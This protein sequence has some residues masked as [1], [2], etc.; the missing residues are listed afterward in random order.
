MNES[1]KSKVTRRGFLKGAAAGA[2]ALPYAITSDALGASGRPPASDRI[3]MGS[4]GI[5]GRGNHDLN[6]MIG[7]KDV[8][9]AAVCDVRKTR[10]E[11]AKAL[12]ND[13]YK[14]K[15]CVA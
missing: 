15:D 8:Q 5:G 13:K 7:E 12:I 1:S 6:W 3:V 14:T 4:I 9:F 10:R 2:I 11:Y